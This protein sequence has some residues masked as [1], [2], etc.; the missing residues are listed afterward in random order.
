MTT[1][2][3]AKLVG[4]RGPVTINAS[5]DEAASGPAS[6]EA[7]AYSGGPV[8]GYS[9]TPRFDHPYVVDLRGMKAARKPMANLDHEEDHR[10]GHLTAVDIGDQVVVKGLLSAATQYRDEV[11]RSAADEFPWEVSMEA[12]LGGIEKLAAGKSTTVNGQTV[13]GPLYIVR[14][15]TFTGL[16]FVGQGADD[17]NSVKV[18]ASAAGEN[19]MTD[20]EKWLADNEFDA[21]GMTDKQKVKMEAAYNAEKAGGTVTKPSRSPSLSAIVDAERH[22]NERVEAITRMSHQA[23]KDKPEWIDAIAEMADRAIKE[24]VDQDKFEL[25]LLRGTRHSTGAFRSTSKSEPDQKVYEAALCR[26]AGLPGYEKLYSEQVLDAVDRSGMKYFS[27]QQ[28]L[29][30]AACSNGYQ[31]TPGERITNGNIKRVLK[32]A[33]PDEDAIQMRASGQFSTISLPGIFSSVANKEILAGFTEEDNLWREISRIATSANFQPQIA[34]RLTDNFEFEELP[35]GKEI[36]HGSLGEDTY[37]RTLKTY[38]KMFGL[39][40]QDILNDDLSA[41]DGLRTRLGAGGARKLNSVYWAAFLNNASFFTSGRGN[42]IEGATTNLGTDGVGL[43]AGVAAFK[44]LESSDGKRIGGQP[45]ILLVPPELEFI[46]DRLFVGGTGEAQT[47]ANTNPF[48]GKYRPVTVP[49]LSDSSFSGYSTTAWYLFRNPS[50][51]APMVVSF[52]N[53][54][55]TPTVESTDADFNTLGILFRGFWDFGVNQAEYLGG[56][57]SK[58][59]A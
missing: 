5:A 14:R 18:A 45:S 15:S 2:R 32:Y 26:A 53:G 9:T 4:M 35:K 12:N 50:V 30:K 23:M 40:R 52:L 21:E 37:T 34:Y 36:A 13:T 17:S 57:K 56:I 25:E 46:A 54:N 44:R 8:P 39:D 43:T 6:F 3:S 24:K 47:V 1:P 55:Q 38:A 16:A 51:L 29:I 22:E 41:F 59:A 42:Y 20:F 27:L 7:V 49:Q 31:A 33:F 10:V 48:R 28:M 19:Q 58:G 11:A